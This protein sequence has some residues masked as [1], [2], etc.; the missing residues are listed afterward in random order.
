MTTWNLQSKQCSL[1]IWLDSTRIGT[2]KLFRTMKI[3]LLSIL[4]M[5]EIKTKT[6]CERAKH[7]ELVAR[8]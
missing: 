4:L 6:K 1:V 7:T 3:Y 2:S 5:E 8:G